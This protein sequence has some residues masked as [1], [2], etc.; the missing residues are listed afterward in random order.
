M[1]VVVTGLKSEA[2]IL[3]GQGVA[4]ISV[5]GKADSAPARIESAVAQGA[6]GLVSFGIAGA[7]HPDLRTGDLV[8]GQT[9]VDETGVCAPAHAEWVRAVVRSAQTVTPALSRGPSE[10]QAPADEWIP[11]QGRDDEG[12]G[13]GAALRCACADVAL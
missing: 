10:K 7:L 13:S 11:A 9:V 12:C 1:L 4:C 3:R 6:T 8:V 2:K 5:G